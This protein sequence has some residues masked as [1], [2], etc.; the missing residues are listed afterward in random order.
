MIPT[1]YQTEKREEDIVKERCLERIHEDTRR[2]KRD[3]RSDNYCEVVIET[4]LQALDAIRNT[5][6]QRPSSNDKLLNIR[7]F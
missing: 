1:K 5:H 4:E 3:D 6:K 7:K 2:R